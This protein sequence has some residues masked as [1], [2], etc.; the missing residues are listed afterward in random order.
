MSEVVA[1]TKAPTKGKTRKLKAKLVIPDE[2]MAIKDQVKLFY[3]Q[4]EKDP[5]HFVYTPEGALR[6]QG[7]EGVADR[8]LPLRYFS[9]LQPEERQ[10]LETRRMDDMMEVETAYDQALLELREAV[11]RYRENGFLAEDANAVVRA[12]EEVR[13]NSVLRSSLAYP[14]KWIDVVENPSVNEIFLRQRYEDRKMGYDVFLFKRQDMAF[15][16]AWG[17]YRDAPPTEVMAGGGNTNVIFITDAEEKDTGIFHP[18]FMREFVFTETRYVSPYQAFEAERFKE[19]GNES[20][21]K[22]ILGT[23]SARTIHNIA[24]KEDQQIMNVGKRW[25]DILDAFYSQHKDLSDKLKATGSAKFHLMDK[26]IGSQAFIEAL[27]KT[28]VKLREEDVDAEK[29]PQIA[30]ESVITE[31]EQKLAKKAAIINNFKRR[32][33]F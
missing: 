16:D 4:R 28:R 13:L 19:L 17:H 30:K 25:E 20:I 33:G 15:Q 24:E 27:E 8:S 7:V 6:I 22:Q 2:S 3:Q 18:A 14:S 23:R 21:R 9:A 10:E 5:Q 11:A 12:N 31:D 32:G 1:P 29:G 26:Q